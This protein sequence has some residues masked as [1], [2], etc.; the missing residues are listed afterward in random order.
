MVAAVTL[1]VLAGALVTIPVAGEAQQSATI[2]RIGILR[3][4]AP[5]DPLVE[6]FRTELR[7]LGYVEGRS[8]H[9]EY[10]W[11]K[12]IDE[13]LQ[14][15]ANELARLKVDVI[16]A[17]GTTPALTARRATA[18]IPIV[19]PASSDPVRLGLVASLAR[20]GGNV[21]GL[22][23]QNDELPAKWLELLKE[24]LPGISRVAVLWD[25]ANDAGQ[26]KA[27]E[28]GAQSLR[29]ASSRAEGRAAGRVRCRVRRGARESRRCP[30]GDVFP[31]LLR[32]S[33]PPGRARGQAPTSDDLPP[34]GIRRG[35][36]GL[37]SYGPDF[38]DMFRRAARYVDKILKGAKPEVSCP[39]SNR[40][41]S[42]W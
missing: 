17:S 25:P 18:T 30:R 13:Q 39:S 38:R 26:S 14:G 6:A 22:T 12:G 7:E 33:D 42:S 40:R 11:A 16:V 23:S 24:A 9:I 19:M 35:S 27:A 41:D 20:P 21:T 34:P 28:L 31:T 5:P 36:G 10:R 29:P 15:L 8:I 4:G 3:S 32:A 2:P 37:I 1:G